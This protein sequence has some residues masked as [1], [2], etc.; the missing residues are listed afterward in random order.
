[1]TLRYPAFVAAALLCVGPI[2]LRAQQLPSAWAHPGGKTATPSPALSAPFSDFYALAPLSDKAEPK[3]MSDAGG[4]TETADPTAP[5]AAAAAALPALPPGKDVF[6]RFKEDLSKPLSGP[7]KFKRGI[8]QVIFPGI[9]A[10]AAAAGLSMAWDSDL[11][12]DY[13]MGGRGFLRRFTS[14]FGENAVGVML[15]DVALATL[16]H[17]DPR[18]HPYA[19]RGFGHRLWHAI[20][21][22]FITQTDDGRAQFN[23]SH[24]T[25]IVV[26]AGAATAWHHE[27]DRRGSYFGERVG[28]SLLTSIGYNIA[29]E[30]IFYH[31]YPRQ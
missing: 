14:D 6:K 24:L 2:G 16:W 30:F 23:A 22:T 10:S 29:K 17:Q 26:G 9:P 5:P 18:Y 11:D 1:M 8:I 15:G 25:G 28:W 4:A 3:R 21:R 20:T 27:S 7:A 31:D 19:Y 13:G 12:H